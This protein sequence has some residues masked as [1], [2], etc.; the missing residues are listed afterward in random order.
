MRS[1]VSGDEAVALI[2]ESPPALVL[3]DLWM[4]RGSGWDLLMIIQA[5]WPH[6]PVLLMTGIFAKDET[7]PDVEEVMVA[8]D[9]AREEAIRRERGREAALAGED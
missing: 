4:P 8:I 7:A 1:A 3:T 9:E 6:V 2:A 5:R